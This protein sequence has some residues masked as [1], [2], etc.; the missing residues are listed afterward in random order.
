MTRAHSSAIGLGLMLFC[1]ALFGPLSLAQDGGATQPQSLEDAEWV[2][3]RANN[4][5]FNGSLAN[6]SVQWQVDLGPRTPGSEPSAEFRQS[7]KENVTSWGWNTT[8]QI[9]Q[10]G[11]MTLTNLFATYPSHDNLKRKQI[12]IS[13]HYDSRYMADH[14]ANESNR[15]LPVPGA[16]DAASGAAVLFELARI[17]PS[18]NLSEEIVLFWN[19]GEDQ[20]N[21]SIDYTLG[22]EAWAENLTAEQQERIHAF[23]LLDMVGDADLQLHN[24]NPGNQTLKDRIILLG[25]ALGLVNGS[26][27]CNGLNGTDVIQYNKQVSVIDDHIH[28]H[29]LN[30]PS[31]DLMDTRY[32]EAKFGTFGTY[33]HTLEDTPE[34]VSASSLNRVGQIVEL[35]LLTQAFTFEEPDEP[36]IVSQPEQQISETEVTTSS[37]NTSLALFA[38]TSL[39]FLAIGVIA[40][41]RQLKS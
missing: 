38:M 18:L 17:I 36:S 33:W 37:G 27:A 13:A 35:G 19:D 4:L 24:V 14:D 34:K 30:I 8:E 3:D 23:V 22:A 25:S 10:R 39:A 7:I 40:L 6:E 1:T 31:I 2:C 32:G 15:D 26:N 28:A 16:N 11:D 41:E 5:Q 21:D 20:G 12:I 29:A 9:H